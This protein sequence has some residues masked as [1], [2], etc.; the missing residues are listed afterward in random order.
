MEAAGTP[1]SIAPR[2]VNVGVPYA[3]SIAEAVNRCAAFALI[4]SREADASEYVLREVEL[5]VKQRRAIA[6]L[7]VEDVPPSG[8]LEFYLAPIHWRDAFPVVL[9]EHVNAFVEDVRAL[10]RGESNR[11]ATK[12]ASASPRPLAVDRRRLVALACL[13]GFAALIIPGLVYFQIAPPL[14]ER[15]DLAVG[16]LT[17]L[18][19]L[20]SA[21]LSAV[22]RPR[23][24]VG[25]LVRLTIAAAVSS[26][27]FACLYSAF[28][29]D[30]APADPKRDLLHPP[31]KQT[32]G[33][34]LSKIAH[35]Y[36]AISP[37]EDVEDVLSGEQ[38]DPE[39]VWV[40]WTIVV[41]RG[42]FLTSWLGLIASLSALF[43]SAIEFVSLRATTAAAVPARKPDSALDSI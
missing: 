16:L 29:Y 24:A 28:V 11:P 9:P 34:L 18:G 13:A 26:I 14:D 17:W 37:G 19:V 40:H 21:T 39:K 41:A 4:F 31:P 23:N 6:I 25:R 38:Y 1:C 15:Y 2:N 33:F 30:A 7:R 3:R 43:V 5:A 8:S 12:L 32:G 27:V 10:V 20:A 42:L 22:L 35:D 36:L